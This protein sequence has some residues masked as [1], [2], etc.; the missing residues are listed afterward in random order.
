MAIFLDSHRG[1]DVPSDT[2]RDFMRAATR[3]T[4]DQ[5]GVRPLDL[6]CGDDGDVHYVV[7]A[8]DETAIRQ[9]HAAHG[10]DCSRIRHIASPQGPRVNFGDREKALVR[11][12]ILAQQGVPDLA[13]IEAEA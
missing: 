7:A 5:F 6:Y 11:R 10:A 13:G 12:L 8:P 9:S 2:I 4:P 1:T 3:G